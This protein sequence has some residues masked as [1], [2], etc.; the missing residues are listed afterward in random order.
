MKIHPEEAEL[1][2]ADRW[3]DR[4]MNRHDKAFHSFVD[5]LKSISRWQHSAWLL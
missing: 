2:Y 5:A 1:L 4:Q 3:T